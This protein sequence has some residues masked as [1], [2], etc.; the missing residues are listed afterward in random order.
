MAKRFTDTNKYKKS[1]IR[2]LPGPYKLLWDFLYHDCDHAGVWIVD[3]EMAQLFLGKDMPVDR[4]RALELFNDEEEVRVVEVDGG[5]KWFL[6]GFIEFQYTKLKAENRAHSAAILQLQKFGLLEADL[7]V[8]RS[9]KKNPSIE[10]KPLISPLEGAKDKDKDKEQEKDKEKDSTR[11]LDESDDYELFLERW[12]QDALIEN[13][14]ILS[15]MM[16]KDALETGVPWPPGFDRGAGILEH[17]DLARRYEWRFETQTAFRHSLLKVLR[18]NKK[19]KSNGN[20]KSNPVTGTE[21]IAP[22]KDFSGK[23]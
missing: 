9:F 14:P 6:P 22:G 10:N 11:G 8:R 17:R 2:S 21:V 15:Q 1:F 4:A 7:S 16:I 13:D 18:D 3:F 19:F 5:K 20:H 12:T 23:F